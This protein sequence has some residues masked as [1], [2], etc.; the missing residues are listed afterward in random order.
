MQN[1]N[2]DYIGSNASLDYINDNSISPHRIP[3]WGQSS[4]YIEAGEI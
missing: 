4:D 3:Y 1:P 2:L